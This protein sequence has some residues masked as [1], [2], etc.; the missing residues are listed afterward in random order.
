MPL[1][2]CQHLFVELDQEPRFAFD[3]LLAGGDGMDRSPRWLAYAAHLDEPVPV[4]LGQLA[5]L[6]AVPR[7]W[8]DEASLC[9]RHGEAAV[10]SLLA[11]GLLI[12]DAD[13]HAGW[14]DRDD[15]TRDIAWWPPALMAQ[16][17]G[18]WR[19]LD[20]QARGEQGLMLSSQQMVDAFGA[21]PEPD[22]R[23]APE[24][25]PVALPL[26]DRSEF[27]ELLAR[28][29]TCRN[30]D[31]G[32]TLAQADFSAMLRRV[33]GA[34]GTRT[35][36][37][38]AVAVKK[39]SPAGGG[40]H[41][42]EAYVLVR[43]VEGV[44][45]GLYHYLSMRHALEPLQALSADEAAALA[46]RFVA[47]QDWFEDVP[48]MVVMTARFDRLFWKYRR[49]AKAWRV[50]H[51]D[52]GHLSQTMYL[53]ATER[54]L[55]CFVTAAINDRAVDEAL[56]LRPLREAAIALV[57]FGPRAA[58]MRTMELDQFDPVELPA[59]D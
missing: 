23:R 43:R 51:L 11:L 31:A 39:T 12:S 53:S 49:H 15:A 14:R 36:A 24:A 10:H 45:P 19:D 25:T 33:W 30:F 26:A 22:Y 46:H 50:V 4:A 8:T 44:A 6:Q 32:A 52:V 5:L 7:D 20:I 47:G 56:G 40:L 2:R 1:R 17:H 59:T 58:E 55:G 54:G 13:E 48:V 3:T 38:G 57:G 41:A 35:L 18:G 9:D 16:A 28:R 29:R 27:D 21:A 37:P 34:L 42:V